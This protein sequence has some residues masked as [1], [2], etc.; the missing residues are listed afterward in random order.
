MASQTGF[1][2]DG[3]S[4]DTMDIDCSMAFRMVES[5]IKRIMSGLRERRENGTVFAGLIK[6]DLAVLASQHRCSKFLTSVAPHSNS[7]SSSQIPYSYPSTAS[8]LPQLRSILQGLEELS[9]QE[10]PQAAS[11]PFAAPSRTRAAISVLTGDAV[12]GPTH[13]PLTR[14]SYP[15]FPDTQASALSHHRNQARRELH[16]N[17]RANT[18]SSLPEARHCELRERAESVAQYRRVANRLRHNRETVLGPGKNQNQPSSSGLEITSNFPRPATP[19]LLEFHSTSSL[20][21]R[22]SLPTSLEDL[23]ELACLVRLLSHWFAPSMASESGEKPGPKDIAARRTDTP[24]RSIFDDYQSAYQSILS[25]DRAFSGTSKVGEAAT[26]SSA[27]SDLSPPNNPFA[28]L[29]PPSYGTRSASLPESRD[30]RNSRLSN[31]PRPKRRTNFLRPISVS[32]P[33]GHAIRP[34][35]MAKHDSNSS[36]NF[37]SPRRLNQ[38]RSPNTKQPNLHG[39]RGRV[40]KASIIGSIVKRHGDESDFRKRSTESGREVEVEKSLDISS[41][42]QSVLDDPD[43]LRSSPAGEA[44]TIPLPPDP[45]CV[46]AKGLIAETLSEI[47]LYENTEKLLNLTHASG[48]GT[49]AGRKASGSPFKSATSQKGVLN[50]E[51]SWMGNK[52]KTSFRDLSTKELNQLRKSVH[53]QAGELIS[54]SVIDPVGNE[55]YNDQYVLSNATYQSPRAGQR[56]TTS[57]EL[58]E[59]DAR[60]AQLLSERLATHSSEQEQKSFSEPPAFDQQNPKAGVDNTGELGSDSVLDFGGPQ[61]SS[62]RGVSLD[63]ALKD[64]SFRPG[65]YMDESSM[66]SLVGRESA[67]AARLSAIAKGKKVIRSAKSEEEEDLFTEGDGNDGGEWETVGESGMQRDLRTQVSIGR[68][69]SGSSLANVSSNESAEQ[70]KA[71]PSPWD[72]LRSHP[73]FV[74]PPMKAVIHRYRRNGKT[75]EV[76]DPATVPRYVPPHFEGHPLPRLNRITSST[77]ALPHIATPTNQCRTGQS[78]SY[79]HP[80]PLSGEH[81]NPFSSSPPPVNVNTPGS[82]FE[83]SELPCKHTDK[84]Q[85]IH[86]DSPHPLH[87]THTPT[88]NTT[89]NHSENPF[90]TQ[91]T[92]SDVSE[93]GSY[94]TFYPTNLTVDGSSILHPNS[95]HTP[96]SAKSYTP[97]S[98]QRTKQF[99]TGSPELK[100]PESRRYQR[101]PEG[102]VPSTHQT[103]SPRAHIEE[104]LMGPTKPFRSA[105]PLPDLPASN[106]FG[107]T[108]NQPLTSSS[109]DNQIA[110]RMIMANNDM[111]TLKKKCPE[112]PLNDSMLKLVF[113]NEDGT[114]TDRPKALRGTKYEEDGR[115]FEQAWCDVHNR[116]EF[117]HAPRLTKRI[118]K[119]DPKI[120]REMGR[121]IV[122]WLFLSVIGWLPLIF[123]VAWDP[124]HVRDDV[125]REWTKG[126]CQTFHK[127]EI[128]LARM[129]TGFIGA[130]VAVALAL[131]GVY[132]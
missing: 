126:T 77:P 36:F 44:P 45:S 56:S 118:P 42:R 74:T 31:S 85:A 98:I 62:S 75:F 86:A 43:V 53:E 105:N 52:G 82:S 88:P 100:M 7:S 96:K 104:D 124:G 131:V 59:A 89:N 120:Q 64:G 40:E 69:T 83:L 39:A 90:A 11:T 71:A 30:R 91:D 49:L 92:C 72:P 50:S 51:F 8:L 46:V 35:S 70:V 111:N 55:P 108:F 34:A 129:L 132:L 60:A 87:Q 102:R 76:Q 18:F 119:D 63:F 16:R 29:S 3:C 127:K 15:E 21:L 20:V 65:L 58:V 130:V 54:Q 94:L 115:I 112:F 48:T 27:D 57:D 68:D 117:S 67:E 1:C 24:P 107:L 113:R 73:T 79:R 6:T 4:I 109:T 84:R 13:H 123:F 93:D 23:E 61:S 81:Q 80:T 97:G 103:A 95:Q 38:D 37:G 2:G 9:L 14:L 116:W 25:P 78:P 101:I 114:A 32:P 99:L 17:A 33:S 122:L 41:P 5:T 106:N 28:E 47:S 19:D 10:S 110:E 66:A 128:L 12:T 125:M 26:T 22:G 121:R